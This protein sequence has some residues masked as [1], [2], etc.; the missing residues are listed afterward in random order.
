MVTPN[1]VK[2]GA[3]FDMAGSGF[4]PDGLVTLTLTGVDNLGSEFVFDSAETNDYG[5]FSKAVTSRSLGVFKGLE[6][7]A[8]TVK[9]EDSIGGTATYPLILEAAE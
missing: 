6:P 9:A 1:K 7:G 4:S 5:A 3:S 8:Y 2:A